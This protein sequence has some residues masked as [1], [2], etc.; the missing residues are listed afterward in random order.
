MILPKEK[1]IGRP[2]LSSGRDSSYKDNGILLHLLHDE[3]ELQNRSLLQEI[4]SGD[5]DDQL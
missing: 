4:D 1:Q 5:E 3:A 2:T